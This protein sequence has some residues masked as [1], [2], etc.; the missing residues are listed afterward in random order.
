MKGFTAYLCVLTMVFALSSCDGTYYDDIPVNV[1]RWVLVES[2]GMPVP[3]YYADYYDFFEN[4]EGLHSY[5][6]YY[7]RFVSDPFV[8]EMRRY[9]EI[10]IRYMDY[11]IGSYFYYFDYDG[12]YLYLSPYPDFYDYDVYARAGW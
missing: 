12:A 6:D 4:G 1:G 5:Y 2:G 10:Y 11:S 3:D 8:W 7:G 9:G